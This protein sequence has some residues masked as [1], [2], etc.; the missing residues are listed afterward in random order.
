MH[1]VDVI[2][3]CHNQAP[4]ITEAINSRVAQGNGVATTVV[5]DASTDDSIRIAQAMNTGR[6]MQNLVGLRR[7]RSISGDSQ[8][9]YDASR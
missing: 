9:I 1:V 4:W 2:I 8:A 7:A 6:V 3:T 5:D